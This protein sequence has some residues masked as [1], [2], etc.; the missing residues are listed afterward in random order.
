[1]PCL[2]IFRTGSN[3]PARYH[4]SLD[5]YGHFSFTCYYRFITGSRGVVATTITGRSESFS[6]HL[7]GT[8]VVFST[9]LGVQEATAIKEEILVVA[10]VLETLECP[11]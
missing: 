1:M 10:G 6:R 8:T 2:P 11:K 9:K 4:S 7:C 5:S 3:H